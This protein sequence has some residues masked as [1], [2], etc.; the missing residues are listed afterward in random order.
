M[1]LD[2][3]GQNL[4]GRNFKGRQDLA[5]ANFSYADIRGANF[6]NVNLTGANFRHIKAGLQ[7]PWKITYL[8]LISSLFL[9][10]S[11]FFSYL[12]YYFL[13]LIFNAFSLEKQI[14]GCT[15][16]ILLI[17]FFLSTILQGV[18]AGLEAFAFAFTGAVAVAAFAKGGTVA[19][20]TGAAVG[21]LTVAVVVIVAVAFAGVVAAFTETVAA[22]GAIFIIA[23]LASAV[24]VSFAKPTSGKIIVIVII[25]G[26][27]ALA[28]AVTLFSIYIGWRAMKGDEKYALIR[29]IAV[30]FA[31][32]E[33]TSFC[34]ANLTN[35]DF[36]A[37]TLKSTDFRNTILS[38]TCWHQAKMLDRVRP[39]LTYL[40]DSQVRQL[41]VTGQGQDKNFYRENLRGINLQKAN[42]ADASFIG[43]DL[44]EANLQDADLSRANLKQTQLDGTDLT[45]ATLTGAFIEDWGIT[46]TTKLHGVRC[47]YVFM[48]LPTKEDPDPLRKPDNKQE[49]FVDGDF[50]NFI[51]PIFD[52]LDLYHNQGVDPR[53]VAI[54]FKNLAENHPEAELEIVAM[55][56]RGDDK[57]LLRAKTAVG[58]DKSQLSAEYFDDYNQLKALSQSQQLLL[59]EKDKRI[60]SLENMVDTALKQPKFYTQGDTNMSDISGIN[61]EGSSNV[62]GIA[63]NSSIANL[64]TISGNVSIA[65]NELPDATDA[66]KPGIKELLSQLQDA[67]VQSTYLSEEDKA[68]ALEQVNALA[69]AGKNPQESTKQ[70]TAKTAI[71]MLKGIFTGLP[72][73]ASL[74]EATN[75]LLPAIS[76]LFGLG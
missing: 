75:K 20:F 64:G 43:A 27:L 53:A 54:A 5:G 3:S 7:Q 55:E 73:V 57:I 10:L 4:R 51:K 72:A 71:T 38:N 37:A 62:S 50:A 58:S 59:V 29:N 28:F 26:A 19:A 67:I 68:E 74:V 70:K 1:A 61:I 56:K 60:I 11:G 49:V 69:E 13:P 44:S 33:G 32:I 30:G 25:S 12:T 17:A 66:E 6:T 35:A 52:T 76:K 41:L 2:F 18:G 65:L 31:A 47:E 15:T 34:G 63:G 40:Q 16:L 48:R 22:T 14:T 42:L 45:G 46:N 9:V 23:A 8:A 21:G 39:G 36:T 24:A